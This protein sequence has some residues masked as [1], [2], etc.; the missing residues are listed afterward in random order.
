[1]GTRRITGFAAGV[2]GEVE[3]VALR[4]ACGWE[5]SELLD[6]DASLRAQ[7]REVECARCGMVGTMSM[8][9]ARVA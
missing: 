6:A 7:L 5:Q 8:A 9:K 3:T 1:M 2:E 4:C